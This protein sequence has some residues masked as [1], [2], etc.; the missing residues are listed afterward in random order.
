MKE[1]FL[2]L[3]QGLRKHAD[4]DIDS[5]MLFNFTTIN[6]IWSFITGK[7]FDR[8]DP[9]DFDDVLNITEVFKESFDL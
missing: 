5:H 6:I 8:D 1:E 4:S 2:E 7:R 9:V 3:A